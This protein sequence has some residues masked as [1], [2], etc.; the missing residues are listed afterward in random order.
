[1][2]IK[3]LIPQHYSMDANNIFYGEP[4]IDKI[5]TELPEGT[6]TS[7]TNE[8]IVTKG[9]KKQFVAMTHMETK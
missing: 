6:E 7:T 2:N 8:F 4:T 1:M 3:V 5:L 9:L